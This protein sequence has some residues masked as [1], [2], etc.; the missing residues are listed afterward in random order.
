MFGRECNKQEFMKTV[1]KFEPFVVLI[2]I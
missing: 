1:Q 2:I